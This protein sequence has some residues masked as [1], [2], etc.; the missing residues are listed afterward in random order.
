MGGARSKTAFLRVFRIPFDYSMH[1][2]QKQFYPK[3][4][5]P[6]ESRDSEGM[7]FA[8]LESVTRYLADIGPWMVLKS[9]HVTIMKIENL[10]I[11]TRRKIHWFQRCYSFRS[12][13]KNNEVIAENR[14][15]TVASSLGACGRLAVLN[16]RSSSIHS[17]SSEITTASN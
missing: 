5:V 4:M 15:Q 1:S 7:P 17:S 13:T 16:W 3:P 12:M 11:D 8:S 6:M 2:L 9:G 10:Q 14:F